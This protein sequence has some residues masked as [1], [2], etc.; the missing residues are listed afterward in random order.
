MNLAVSCPNNC[1]IFFPQLYKG[2]LQDRTAVVVRCLKLKQKYV[3]QNLTQYMDI[4]S[5]LRHKHLVSII[6]HCISDVQDISNTATMVYLVSE[7]VS[8]GTL[9]SHLT[10]NYYLIYLA[11]YA[12]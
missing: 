12:K 11:E 2:W 9:R 8:N 3:S 5:K 6:G 1:F 7:F 4:I 10:G